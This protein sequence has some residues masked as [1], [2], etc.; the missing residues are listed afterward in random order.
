M[1]SKEKVCSDPGEPPRSGSR[2]QDVEELEDELSNTKHM[3][4]QLRVVMKKR[5][6]NSSKSK[7]E[8]EEIIKKLNKVKQRQKAR[9]RNLK[10]R[11]VELE[12]ESSPPMVEEVSSSARKPE[13]EEE[14]SLFSD[15]VASD[16]PDD[17]DKMSVIS[18]ISLAESVDTSQFS[19]SSAMMTRQ[20]T[21]SRE[22]CVKKLREEKRKLEE[23]SRRME[24]TIR[25]KN[26]E[27]AELQ[28]PTVVDP[29][30]DSSKL[31]SSVR[32]II[33]LEKA[34]NGM[35]ARNSELENN[36]FGLEET[37]REKDKI[38]EARTQAVALMSENL[39]KKNKEMS[40]ALEDTRKEIVT[41]QDQFLAKQ[42]AWDLER[43]QILNDLDQESQ[44]AAKLA[45]QAQVL[46]AV[47]YDLSIRNADLQEKIVRMQDETEDRIR[48]LE[49]DYQE[50]FE[51]LDN[52]LKKAKNQLKNQAKAKE[53]EIS[54]LQAQIELLEAQLT[55]RENKNLEKIHALTDENG[56]LKGKL[57]KHEEVI[58]AMEAHEDAAEWKTQFLQ[59]NEQISVHVTTISSLE[60]DK[61]QL[62][63]DVAE[64][65]RMISK[66]KRKLGKIS[67]K[68]K[69]PERREA[70]ENDD[71]S[72]VPTASEAEENLA[73]AADGVENQRIIASLMEEV[74]ELRTRA[75]DM[76]VINF[77]GMTDLVQELTSKDARIC[78]LENDLQ[79]LQAKLADFEVE[80]SEKT[81][82]IDDLN[83][84]LELK[85]S[86]GERTEAR[87]LKLCEELENLKLQANERLSSLEVK[88]EELQDAKEEL[89]KLEDLLQVKEQYEN[90]IES[91]RNAV[92]NLESD[93]AASEET[94]VRLR[95]ELAA[96]TAAFDSLTI[97][98]DK[99]LQ[100]LMDQVSQG[101]EDE[102]HRAAKRENL[103]SQ[104][105][106]LNYEL[107]AAR[108]EI[109][110]KAVELEELTEFAGEKEKLTASCIDELKL[111]VEELEKSLSETS[112]KF[113]QQQETSA[114]L[115]KLLEETQAI[116]VEREQK[117]SELENRV[118][119]LELQRAVS[120]E[121]VMQ[122][123]ATDAEAV[124]ELIS[125][126]DLLQSDV[127]LMASD[128][129][130]MLMD[131]AEQ[132]QENAVLRKESIALSEELAVARSRID[133][134]QDEL[135]HQKV[136][137][138]E[139]QTEALN[140]ELEDLTKRLETA[141]EELEHTRKS[142]ENAHRE[143]KKIL[144]DR[145]EEV[146]HAEK[147]IAELLADF[148]SQS[149][150]APRPSP[151]FVPDALQSRL[152]SIFRKF[153]IFVRQVSGVCDNVCKEKV[154]GSERDEWGDWDSN[155]SDT[156]YAEIPW[157]KQ[158]LEEP[159]RF[160]VLP[161]FWE[162]MRVF[163]D[164]VD[165][166]LLDEIETL[167][168]NR[169]ELKQDLEN[170][171]QSSNWRQRTDSEVANLR[172]QRDSL[173]VQLSAM[174]DEMLEMRYKCDDKEGTIQALMEEKNE[175]E[176]RYDRL[177][178]KTQNKE[179]RLHAD[180][181]AF[182]RASPSFSVGEL[183]NTLHRLSCEVFPRFIAGD[184]PE[185]EAVIGGASSCPN[186]SAE[187]ASVITMEEA[188]KE[189][190]LQ[191]RKR[192]FEMRSEDGE[193]A[194]IDVLDELKDKCIMLKE[195]LEE[196]R[197]DAETKSRRIHD[198]QELNRRLLN[199]TREFNDFAVAAKSTMNVIRQE[200]L[201]MKKDCQ[202]GAAVVMEQFMRLSMTLQDRIVAT[203]HVLRA[204][205]EIEQQYQNELRIMKEHLDD[206]K[207]ENERL[208]EKINGL[209]KC[210]F[211]EHVENQVF[212]QDSEI[213]RL[214]SELEKS[215]METETLKI[216]LTDV[217]K[218]LHALQ[219]SY[220]EMQK[221]IP[222][223]PECERSLEGGHALSAEL[224]SQ[225]AEYDALKVKYTKA[226]H[227]LKQLKTA[228]VASPAHSQESGRDSPQLTQSLA[229]VPD[230]IA[231]NEEIASLRSELDR[232]I[233]AKGEISSKL[234]ISEQSLMKTRM[235]V[236]VLRGQVG[237]EDVDAG[238]GGLKCTKEY[239]SEMLESKERT[240]MEVVTQRD[241]LIKEKE[242]LQVHMEEMQ[243]K[244]ANLTEENSLLREKLSFSNNELQS[245][246]VAITESITQRDS[247]KQEK[248]SL[249]M[250]VEQV[251]ENLAGVT[252]ENA[253]LQA[254]LTF[255]KNELERVQTDVDNIRE[256]STVLT[257]DL[258]AARAAKDLINN[259]L[260]ERDN[261]IQ[262]LSQERVQLDHEIS[263]LN[264]L[265]E[266]LSRVQMENSDL[267]ASNMSLLAEKDSL[268]LSV[269]ELR[270]TVASLTDE[271]DSKLEEMEDNKLRY[272][273]L[274]ELLQTR[275]KEL[276]DERNSR[277]ELHE[278]V[279]KLEENLSAS[280][281]QIQ[282][283]T[284]DITSYKAK[285]LESDE[286]LEQLDAEHEELIAALESKM[287]GFRD[288]LAFEKEK[289]QTSETL[290]EEIAVLQR[291]LKEFEALLNM[292]EEE[293]NEVDATNSQLE[294]D[295]DALRG[296]NNELS[297][298]LVSF[299]EELQSLKNVLQETS[300]D[301][302]AKMD[303]L[304]NLKNNLEDVNRDSAALSS[305]NEDLKN[306]LEDLIEKMSHVQEENEALKVE[307][308]TSSKDLSGLREENL[309]SRDE[310]SVRLAEIEQERELSLSAQRVQFLS[311]IEGLRESISAAHFERDRA[312]EE[313][314]DVKEKINVL[315]DAR[316]EVI[317]TDEKLN[318]E[319]TIKDLEGKLAS[320]FAER[321][322]ILNS[323]QAA[324]EKIVTYAS[325]T[326]TLQNHIEEHAKERSSL[327]ADLDERIAENL[328]YSQE[329][330]ALKVENTK[331]SEEV[332]K[333]R[334][335][336]K[337]NE[338]MNLQEAA[339]SNSSMEVE[340]SRLTLENE[341]LSRANTELQDQ[342]AGLANEVETLQSWLG[343]FKDSNV[344]HQSKEKDLAVENQDLLRRLEDLEAKHVDAFDLMAE[345][346]RLESAYE[347]L[348]SAN[349]SM[350]AEYAEMQNR[351]DALK[352]ELDLARSEMARS[353]VVQVDEKE[354]AELRLA[355]VDKDV[356]ISELESRLE[357]QDFEVEQTK[358]I[359]I[360]ELKNELLTIRKSLREHE[361][362]FL[363]KVEEEENLNRQIEEVQR[364]LASK[365]A[366]A[367]EKDLCI[368]SL[369]AELEDLRESHQQADFASEKEHLDQQFEVI[370][371][372]AVHDQLLSAVPGGRQLSHLQ[373][374]SDKDAEYNY[375]LVCMKLEETRKENFQLTKQAQDAEAAL[376]RC[377]GD[378]GDAKQAYRL[379]EIEALLEAA[380]S[381][382][383]QL[384]EQRKELDDQLN[385]LRRRN[386][387]LLNE[388]SD[389]WDQSVEEERRIAA[390]VTPDEAMKME[391]DNTISALHS[392]DVR[393]EE[394]A[395]EVTSLT[396]E[397][398][399][400]Q[401]QLSSALKRELELR[402]ELKKEM[403]SLTHALATAASPSSQPSADDDVDINADAEVARRIGELQQLNYNLDVQLAT[404]REARK[405]L[406]ER[407]ERRRRRLGKASVP[408]RASPAGQTDMEFVVADKEVTRT[409]LCYGDDELGKELDRQWDWEYS[410]T[411]LVIYSNLLFRPYSVVLWQQLLLTIVM[412]ESFMDAD[413]SEID[414]MLA[415]QRNLKD[416]ITPRK[417]PMRE[418]DDTVEQQKT[419]TFS[420][421]TKERLKK[422]GK[423][424]R[425]GDDES[426]LESPL[427]PSRGREIIE[428]E[429]LLPE[430]R[431][432][433][434]E[435][436]VSE[437][438][439]DGR[440]RRLAGL[441]SLVR[442]REDDDEHLGS[443][444]Y[445][446]FVP[447]SSDSP[448][449]E[450][451]RKPPRKSLTSPAPNS[452][453]VASNGK[454]EKEE[455]PS[456]KLNWDPKVIDKLESQG[457][458]KTTSQSR[459]QYEFDLKRS[460]IGGQ[461][462][463]RKTATNNA[464][465]EDVPPESVTSLAKKFDARGDVLPIP[466][467]SSCASQ[468]VQV[469]SVNVVKPAEPTPET[470]TQSVQP[471]KSVSD[472]VK[473]FEGKIDFVPPVAVDPATLTLSQKM[474]LFE[475][476]QQ[477]QAKA[478]GKTVAPAK[479]NPTKQGGPPK[480]PRDPAIQQATK[481]SVNQPAV[482]EP[483]SQA[484]VV[485]AVPAGPNTVMAQRIL[486][487]NVE[488]GWR[489][490]EIAQKTFE[491]KRKDMEV[492][493]N[494]FQR[495]VEVCV[496][497]PRSAV[498]TENA[499]PAW[500][501][502][503]QPA[504]NP[505]PLMAGYI[506][507][508]P[509]LP[510]AH[511]QSSIPANV[512]I[513]TTVPSNS[514]PPPAVEN[515]SHEEYFSAEEPRSNETKYR[516][517]FEEGRLYP[518]LAD[519]EMDSVVDEPIRENYQEVQ[520]SETE[521]TLSEATYDASHSRMS[522]QISYKIA[523]QSRGG[524]YADETTD[525]ETISEWDRES[526]MSESTITSD[527]HYGRDQNF[528][529]TESDA[530]SLSSYHASPG[531]RSPRPASPDRTRVRLNDPRT[532]HLEDSPSGA[533]LRHSLS[534]YRRQKPEVLLTP[535]S[536]KIQYQ[537]K[538]PTI[539]ESPE[540]D[541]PN[542][543]RVQAA[544][545][546]KSIAL[547]IKEL[548]FESGTQLSIMHQASNAVTVC[549]GR[550]EFKLSA[551]RIEAEKLLLISTKRHAAITE[552]I[553]RLKT[554]LDKAEKG[555][556]KANNAVKGTVTI[557]GLS[558]HLKPEFIEYMC[559]DGA[560]FVHHFIILIR[561][562]ENLIP[563]QLLSL[564]S[565]NV[566]K[567]GCLVFD[568]VVKLTDL[569]EDFL[570]HIE[571][572]ALQTKRESIEH[573]VKYH[574]K[575]EKHRMRLTPKKAHHDKDSMKTP[576]AMHN[577]PAIGPGG[578]PAIRKL[579]FGLVGE[580][581]LSLQS[582][583]TSKLTLSKVPPLS[584]LSGILS[585]HVQCASQSNVETSG[586]L[587]VFEEVSK[588]GCWQR[589]WYVLKG[590]Y[591]LF[592][593][594]PDQ[595]Q[596]N[597]AAMGTIDLSE[598]IN[599]D[600]RPLRRDLCARMH[601]FALVVS[602]PA[603]PADCDGL[604]TFRR[605]DR[606]LRR[607]IFAADT[608]EEMHVWCKQLKRAVEDI[609]AWNP[610]AQR[611]SP[612]M[613]EELNGV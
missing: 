594:Y 177:M 296:K 11:I 546:K 572:H 307:L 573:D 484:A 352:F 321:D 473:N 77:G 265:I 496:A 592:W 121:I 140:C 593:K 211:S 410:D 28:K 158:Y 357:T 387:L 105:K 408:L 246:E 405:K 320:L 245:K 266:D 205:E 415:R 268:L 136:A 343:R 543:A 183:Q 185:S 563:S 2:C 80:I 148:E 213:A 61:I 153:C 195:S 89:K 422:M 154:G 33:A 70:S 1:S 510:S 226:L 440:R 31:G 172:E 81:A 133:Q 124:S 20:L 538:T 566:L 518:S 349:D 586:F 519:V 112:E 241:A 393:C 589:R 314:R 263:S 547:R 414:R 179:A 247:L 325:L 178:V 290:N 64:R 117:I 92:K 21:E 399:S 310:M 374:F 558:L 35:K 448:R 376:K 304:Q 168:M 316:E 306:R 276:E 426:E 313:L 251:Q 300:A 401:I 452:G 156:E 308:I 274:S 581:T 391:L 443:H 328:S 512:E 425:E 503:I 269:Q 127:L 412:E 533:A 23:L 288:E 27:F 511:V 29:L 170:V 568:N 218:N 385:L 50:D 591:V 53:E 86:S 57:K 106:S 12:H 174:T 242:V 575:K 460:E 418:V 606:T 95:L 500:R 363:A 542:T 30:P 243:T 340:I 398:D 497:E 353:K 40:A 588:L 17:D 147:R 82:F 487:E 423:I 458:K 277:T 365:L 429:N 515:S 315:E 46:E 99:K 424:F 24:E 324:E 220:N 564:T 16:F 590:I 132:I 259:A 334:A 331:Y 444:E 392:R 612:E 13:S 239:L 492:V 378:S 478:A 48:R 91:L 469:P 209:E 442:D 490:N 131:G 342:C 56:A 165:T 456:K 610:D 254:E 100:D 88:E 603:H 464:A 485:E 545:A 108:A 346:D 51:D 400:L 371:H 294:E 71:T 567:H 145:D 67:G 255:F 198:L 271:S 438:Y 166:V 32:Q 354:L 38:I 481:P 554:E 339:S 201:G 182:L 482:S 446:S 394:L 74:D 232:V 435:T 601:S 358:E 110:A 583:K 79:D 319:A 62:L 521:S 457:F 555:E 96:K 480:P 103:E 532:E 298:K 128:A 351:Y 466:K 305:E 587:T 193:D 111:K 210:V 171:S 122:D 609:R 283:M 36:I 143:K 39:T 382:R 186:F 479:P 292:N 129:S 194:S 282:S 582:V 90:E 431:P 157:W 45:Q 539:E 341:Q 560:E 524:D 150:N 493:L 311:E 200:A 173:T 577:S 459:L 162:K 550:Q 526:M 576:P 69:R 14:I 494:R 499:V 138:N 375:H 520:D 175:L 450:V 215:V 468:T 541:S 332:E 611:A 504:P 474:K 7:V 447:K 483:S 402:K 189:A 141:L 287:K 224:K 562:R 345:K 491:Q 278:R 432:S 513:E 94:A 260:I 191:L 553:Q 383:D 350:Y 167:Q 299:D 4:D 149:A 176:L 495:P 517:R 250:R 441:A 68:S 225:K 264:S 285:I 421:A 159:E 453:P 467:Q 312:L 544:I 119:V 367:S 214:K 102:I 384:K 476:A 372:S 359:E 318:L 509:P 516:V 608:R 107:D 379:V 188:V 59:A 574:I 120:R 337:N 93:K 356:L 580:V 249:E 25:L 333:L 531:K 66:I 570:V 256:T 248:E 229:K 3:L 377:V 470:S 244:L 317:V 262:L 297:C 236:E 84:Q 151:Q 180:Q 73:H 279:L 60:R 471:S 267:L 556:T 190:L 238:S 329:L 22:K 465:C 54:E 281:H 386:E 286:K 139:M 123:R 366:E 161:D 381:E 523:I 207:D 600:F 584:P 335:E 253:S 433:R 380:I 83:E 109:Q 52:D 130:K 144:H 204:R 85:I 535:N 529:D 293:K 187:Q 403:S 42:E 506:P 34:L 514:K 338:G 595:H 203:A 146:V 181:Q 488:D 463:P 219:D 18:D 78:D 152:E 475:K 508:P 75:S 270:S 406:A 437:E 37:V 169:D 327:C 114:E 449:K 579:C 557:S 409:Y 10:S 44:R 233:Q 502:T 280:E 397:R 388:M 407:L 370:P 196:A 295:L 561:H 43:E 537:Y 118:D 364:Q 47:R 552:E 530:T 284:E 231:K 126:R 217:R 55:G 569:E 607:Y 184:E 104:L 540:P 101:D 142:L 362:Q 548:D 235:E 72:S 309:K 368:S 427:P 237:S 19:T 419:S 527:V 135:R 125:E 428:K 137:V 507:T 361:D 5:E 404:E 565:L 434:K 303:D 234:E 599:Q 571:V 302:L 322:S 430:L 221:N 604:T 596:K 439:I 275:E 330:E 222:S 230:I 355:V 272:E 326:D 206:E 454:N 192:C 416:A 164:F 344:D 360:Q 389:Q 258:Q 486:F 323:K 240:M 197:S 559:G 477:E 202:R 605:G 462:S 301:Q 65:D 76:E 26:Q 273:A 395:F 455:L 163:T 15:T 134:L 613:C 291:Q 6:E 98:T 373:N 420:S 348:K 252:M 396:E 261:Q 49:K 417:A 155:V 489:N 9:V 522:R 451:A 578:F 347:E 289:A 411:G 257:T 498:A 87:C 228:G 472:M 336:L 97:E 461:S 501:R 227:R 8:A 63:R 115:S 216:Q 549:A 597:E 585:L 369:K 160:N 208:S 223:A 536:K 534:T 436:T 551:E 598:C 505:V 413:L 116:V 212:E 525:T 445:H 199:T 41:M 390:G 528:V 602:Q 58:L 113:H